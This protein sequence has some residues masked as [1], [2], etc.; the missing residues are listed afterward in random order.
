MNERAV[1]Q[2]TLHLPGEITF[3]QRFGNAW[4]RPAALFVLGRIGQA[5]LV[6][7]GCHG[8]TEAPIF[9]Y[10]MWE[11]SDICKSNCRPHESESRDDCHCVNE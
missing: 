6:R 1:R 11:N 8:L 5:F 3:Y 4:L 9:E 7:P 10:E 2:A